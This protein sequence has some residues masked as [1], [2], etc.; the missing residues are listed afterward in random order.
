[1]TYSG[2]TTYIISAPLILFSKGLFICTFVIMNG[3]QIGELLV[4][5]SA[6]AGTVFGFYKYFKSRPAVKVAIDGNVRITEEIDMLSKNIHSNPIL[7]VSEVT[8]GGGIPA[9]GRPLYSKVIF[10]NDAPTLSLFGDKALMESNMTTIIGRTILKGDSFFIYDELSDPQTK[11]WFKQ[12]DIKKVFVF[13]IGVESGKRA[14]FLF[15]NSKHLSLLPTDQYL[16]C[17][18]T[19]KRLKKLMGLS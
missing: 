15:V 4:G 2:V 11:A 3:T 6:F 14:L 9:I 10:S 18:S 1:M 19:V 13:Y 16:D 8:N 7:F 12:N 5:V 17:V